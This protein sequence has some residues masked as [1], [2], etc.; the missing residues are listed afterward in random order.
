MILENLWE[1][2]WNFKCSAGEGGGGFPDHPHRG[3]ETVTY[4]LA[5]KTEH[6]DFTGRKGTVGPGGLQWM[7]AGRGIVR[8]L[9]TVT[10]RIFYKRRCKSSARH[11]LLYTLSNMYLKFCFSTVTV[12]YY[13]S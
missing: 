12:S 4:M 13:R 10:L 8:N 7:T 2:E 1:N 6:E 3:F 9:L 11:W 5:G